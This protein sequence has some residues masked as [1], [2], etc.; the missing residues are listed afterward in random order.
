MANA[1]NRQFILLVNKFDI[2]HSTAKTYENQQTV[3]CVLCKHGRD[4]CEITLFSSYSAKKVFLKQGTPRKNEWNPMCEK[5]R[6]ADNSRRDGYGGHV[7]AEATLLYEFIELII[8]DHV[9]VTGCG[10]QART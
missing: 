4:R 6:F 5:G 8:H 10:N 1:L 7:I 3:G 9:R 2:Y